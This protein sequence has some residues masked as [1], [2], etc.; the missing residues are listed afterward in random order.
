MRF[1]DE[2]EM[3]CEDY[4]NGEPNFDLYPVNFDTENGVSFGVE[5][6]GSDDEV[7]KVVIRT[8]D[9]TPVDALG[10]NYNYKD[11]Y[12]DVELVGDDMDKDDPSNAPL[13]DWVVNKF[14][15]L[16]YDENTIKVDGKVYYTDEEDLSQTDSDSGED[17]YTKYWDSDGDEMEDSE[18]TYIDDEVDNPEEKIFD[19]ETSD[20][21]ENE[22]EEYSDENTSE[23]IDSEDEEEY[24]TSTEKSPKKYSKIKRSKGQYKKG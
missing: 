18:N 23:E 24:S 14:R 15:N 17:D 20:E 6:E 16:G 8:I 5:K 12:V 21:D 10:G 4:D 13:I 7:A 22:G 1:L 19:M 3:F 11:V 2:V 9:G